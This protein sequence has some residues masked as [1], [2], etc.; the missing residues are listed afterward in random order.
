MGH[1]LAVL[2]DELVGV[3]SYEAVNGPQAAEIALA[4]ADGMHGRG[5][6]TLL[7]EHLVSL[8]RARG[9]QVFTAQALAANTDVLRLVG[10]AGLALQC[11][12]DRWHG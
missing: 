2:G 12:S 7:L 11:K 3:A 4:V 1:C 9:V 10:D 5:V 8:A 6:A